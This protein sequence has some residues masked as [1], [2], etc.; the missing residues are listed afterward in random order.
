MTRPRDLREIAN[1]LERQ[2]CGTQRIYDAL[3]LRIE[4]Q[5]SRSMAGCKRIEAPFDRADSAEQ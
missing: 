3:L 1:D 4:D 2:S 5:M